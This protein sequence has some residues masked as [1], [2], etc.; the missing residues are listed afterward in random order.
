MALEKELETYKAKLPELIAEA[1]KYVLIQGDQV[2]RT[3]SSYEDAMKEGYSEF[4]PD[5]PFLVKRIEAIEHTH[6]ISRFVDP[7]RTSLSQ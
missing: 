1:G 2:I 5:K 7:C 6:F 4:G 3:F